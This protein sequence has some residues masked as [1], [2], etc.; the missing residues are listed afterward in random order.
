MTAAP[1]VVPV[2]DHGVLVVF[3]DEIS[4]ET[5]ARIHALDAALTRNPPAGLAE[6]V[7]AMT[8]LLVVFDPLAT[9]HIAISAAVHDNLTAPSTISSGA[10]HVIDVCYDNEHA[11]DLPALAT[12][13]GLDPE[14]AVA[15]HLAGTYAVG[16]YGFAPGYAYL[17][18]TPSSIQQPRNPTPGP[19]VP[20]GS[21]IIAGQQCLIIPIAMSTGMVR[22]RPHRHVNVHRRSEQAVSVRRRR[23]RHL[24]ADRRGRPPVP[25]CRT[26]P[27]PA[28]S[29]AVL[30]VRRCG[31]LVTIQDAGR[32]GLMRYGV[33]ASGPMDRFAHAAAHVALGRPRRGTAIEVSLGGLSV[34]CTSA[35]VTVSICGGG[36][37]VD[38]AGERCTSWTVRTLV[39]GDTLTISAG[40]WGSWCYLAV[41]GD[42]VSRRWLG[43][44]STHVRADLGGGP[45]RTGDE[46]RIESAQVD[47]AREGPVEPPAIAQPA[48]VL[49]VVLGP[50][51]QCFGPDAGEVLLGSPYALTAAYDRMG[52]RLAGARLPIDDALAIASTPILRGSLQVT[53]DGAPTL[54]LADHQTTGGYPKIAT[55]IADDASRATQLRSGDTVRFVELD[56]PAAIRAARAAADV[57]AH[58]LA[59]VA[60]RPGLRTRRL[61]STNLI[62]GAFHHRQPCRPVGGDPSENPS[63]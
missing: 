4:D 58:H 12:R 54:L 21:V 59:V 62:G 7:P 20:A 49:R 47:D 56:P 30:K 6:I 50:Q 11:P 33:P 24:P 40:D 45:V 31:P 46:L 2:A 52:V 51:P 25:P 15:A 18:G 26:A 35:P 13:A 61:L 43:S 14:G 34:M 1:L 63:L 9:D 37:A 38:H 57:H 10:A 22:H 8:T 16:V 42:L 60:D 48:R 41:A 36:F 32:P 23:P 17:Y 5:Y 55:V 28:M 53:G 3:D 19:V 27:R 39:P 44:T 29:T